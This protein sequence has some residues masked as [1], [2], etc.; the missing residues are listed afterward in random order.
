M[1]GRRSRGPASD[2]ATALMILPYSWCCRYKLLVDAL[3]RNFSSNG[4]PVTFSP[5][6]HVLEGKLHELHG[7]LLDAGLGA[8]SAPVQ[9]QMRALLG[10]A[11]VGGSQ[12]AAGGGK[13][14]SVAN[15]KDKGKGHASKSQPHSQ[16]QSP[17]R[18]RPGAGEGAGY[19]GSGKPASRS[20]S[21]PTLSRL[22]VG[23]SASNA[24]QRASA[25][26]PEQLPASVS[27]LYTKPVGQKKAA[28]GKGEGGSGSGG[29]AEEGPVELIDVTALLGPSVEL[30]IRVSGW[31]G[32]PVQ[33]CHACWVRPTCLVAR[34]PVCFF[35]C[36]TWAHDTVS[37]CSCSCS[38]SACACW[39]GLTRQWSLSS[40][41]MPPQPLDP[42][43]SA[44][45][46]AAHP[47]RMALQAR[48]HGRLC[49]R[50]S[51]FSTASLWWTC[52]GTWAMLLRRLRG[53]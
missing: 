52:T 28:N 41:R 4:T 11:A 13:A 8:Y 23:A 12:G 45:A 42:T 37:T 9:A 43:T 44:T 53:A 2:Y 7:M 30:L 26:A 5:A 19:I 29:G 33:L 32:P 18:T 21:S 27:D 15:A 49:Q 10:P 25:K 14:G 24:A 48:A 47:P 39:S 46:Q 36:L 50:H 22:S 35:M 38:P 40:Q 17:S 31:A 16:Q 34:L 3:K 1:A 6:V 20:P 51:R